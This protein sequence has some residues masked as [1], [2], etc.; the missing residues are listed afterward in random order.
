MKQLFDDCR[1]LI[2]FYVA[3]MAY[4]KKIAGTLENWESVRDYVETSKGNL[5][6][7]DGDVSIYLSDQI[8]TQLNGLSYCAKDEK[9]AIHNEARRIFLDSTPEALFHLF[10]TVCLNMIVN[11]FKVTTRVAAQVVDLTEWQ[12]INLLLFVGHGHHQVPSNR[13]LTSEALLVAVRGGLLSLDR[14]QEVVKAAMRQLKVEFS[15][16]LGDQGFAN[17]LKAAEILLSA[18]IGWKSIQ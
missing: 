15:T 17:F 9:E 14:K 4:Q 2:Q 16:K 8:K 3:M 1:L 11:D 5:W 6:S 10:R 12:T 7:E 18:S 13:R